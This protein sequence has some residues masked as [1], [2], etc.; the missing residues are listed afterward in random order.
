MGLWTIKARTDVKGKLASSTSTQMAFM[1]IEA[2]VGLPGLA[3]LHLIGHGSYKSWCF[4]RAGGAI[5]RNRL[6][7]RPSVRSLPI[8]ILAIGIGLASAAATMWILGTVEVLSAAVGLAA[9]INVIVLS[10][11]HGRPVCKP[12]GAF[13]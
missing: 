11:E 12:H 4:L 1:S 2:A 3:L 7:H 8:T 5:T 10:P 6:G 13:A 9:A